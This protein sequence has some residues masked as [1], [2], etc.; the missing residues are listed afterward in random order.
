M[1]TTELA[2]PESRELAQHIP[3]GELWD[4]R[5]RLDE[6]VGWLDDEL[7]ERLVRWYVDDGLTQKAIGLKVNRSQTVVSQ[8]LKKYGI[9]TRGAGGRPPNP[10]DPVLPPNTPPETYDGEPVEDA[11]IVGEEEDDGEKKWHDDPVALGL[12]S[13]HYQL[14]TIEDSLKENPETDSREKVL[15]QLDEINSVVQRIAGLLASGDTPPRILELAAEWNAAEDAVASAFTPFRQAATEGG[16]LDRKE[17]RKV[18]DP[19]WKRQT[20]IE[21][22]LAPLLL[23]WGKAEGLVGYSIFG[24]LVGKYPKIRERTGLTI[25]GQRMRGLLE[26]AD[27]ERQDK[28][29]RE[30]ILSM[31]DD[32]YVTYMENFCTQ[33]EEG[34]A[35][36]DWILSDL[37]PLPEKPDL[38]SNDGIR[39]LLTEKPKK[40]TRAEKLEQDD[41]L[42]CA[43]KRGEIS[44]EE[45]DAGLGKIRIPAAA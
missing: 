8:R 24:F 10:V 45:R 30:H 12:D 16:K 1:T 34:Q 31:S 29:N 36:K 7:N 15:K 11:E 40:L 33:T 23:E 42:W 27:F 43:W 4:L 39:K 9:E 28:A 6:G 38:L 26:R 3:D 2:I 32:E 21:N 35:L 13:C 19:L 5:D 17:W 20:E 25:G 14:E 44:K 18:A 22:E 41:P 37:R